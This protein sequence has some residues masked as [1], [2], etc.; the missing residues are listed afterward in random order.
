MNPRDVK[1]KL[2][3]KKHD[4]TE[5]HEYEVPAVGWLE[6]VRRHTAALFPGVRT[7]LLVGPPAP[8]GRTLR[9]GEVWAHRSSLAYWKLV[10]ESK[11]ELEARMEVVNGDKA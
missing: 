3:V 7:R 2:L 4:D 5:W 10:R 11:V 9:D 6:H 1:L 8:D